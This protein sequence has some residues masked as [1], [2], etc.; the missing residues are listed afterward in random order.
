MMSN[1]VLSRENNSIRNDAMP[2]L[3][4]ENTFII[5]KSIYS[6]AFIEKCHDSLVDNVKNGQELQMDVVIDM[7][8]KAFSWN[9]IQWIEEEELLNNIERLKLI[10]NQKGLKQQVKL[11]NHIVSIINGDREEVI[12]INDDYLSK[13][14]KPY[15]IGGND[16]AINNNNGYLQDRVIKE[17]MKKQDKDIQKDL[18]N[19][20][21]FEL[22]RDGVLKSDE[23]LTEAKIDMHIRDLLMEY[24]NSFDDLDYDIVSIIDNL[25]GLE[26]NLKKNGTTHDKMVLHFLLC[27]GYFI[28]LW[29][30]K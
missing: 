25:I 22:K 15:V 1:S 29:I 20:L 3:W 24:V 10:L 21:M 5:L 23:S 19:K 27:L 11:L 13:I 9:D 6:R 16:R 26:K 7:I 8:K 4:K 18:L 17:Y 14:F 28:D 2:V 30:M 12:E